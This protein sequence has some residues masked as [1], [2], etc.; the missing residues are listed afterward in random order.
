[1]AT[2]FNPQ[3][4]KEK[5]NPEGSLLRRQ[6]H[7]MTELLLAV[8]RIARKHGIPYWLSSGTLLGAVRHG[9]YIP[10]DD[11]LDI[12][13]LRPDYDR[14][15]K[16]LPDELPE[17]MVLQTHDTDP[18]YF[19]LFAKVRDT[20]SEMSETNRY[21]RIFRHRGIYI[22]I[23]PFEK[24]PLPLHWVSCRA[25]GFTYNVLN[26]PRNDDA[27]ARRKVER[28]YRFNTRVTFPLLRG[29]A[30]LWPTRLVRYG[31]GVPYSDP[32][33]LDDIF[34]LTTIL[35]EGHP[36]PAPRDSHAYLTRKFGDYMQL[37]DLEHL[38]PHYSQLT[39]EEQP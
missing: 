15:M 8:D 2:S 20:R 30:A 6:Q 16:V 10:W 32:R 27:T 3:E 39:I 19:F 28:I 17:G 1:M 23:F 12:E 13:M 36:M 9:G 11:D 24:A 29:L 26:N 25:H 35:F 18:G 5:Y 34:P 38:H 31:W 37:P 21:D 14:L 4:L 7:R 22:D 33:H